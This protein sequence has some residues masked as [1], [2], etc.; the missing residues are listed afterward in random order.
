[1][2]YLERR[3]YKKEAGNKYHIDCNELSTN[4]NNIEITDAIRYKND[5]SILSGVIKNIK[6]NTIPNLK[7]T[8]HIVAKI[9]YSD[10]TLE[11][12]WQIGNMLT[13]IPGY[14][15]YICLFGCFDDSYK[16]ENP[17]R[18]CDAEK[19]PENNKK[20]LIMPYILEVSIK[21]FKWTVD[22]F[23]I[24]RS[25]IIQSIMSAL[26]AYQKIGFIHG[27]FHLD[28]ILLKKTKKIHIE[29]TLETDKGVKVI[30]IPS[31][32]Y[33]IVIMDFENSW[34]IKDKNNESDNLFWLNL[35]NMIS[36]LNWDLEDNDKNKVNF[37][38]L[39]NII[40]YID[41]Q[42]EQNSNCYKTNSIIKI[43]NEMPI[44]INKIPKQ[45]FE[46]NPNIF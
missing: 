12:E 40:T 7:N 43:I 5:V 4:T 16:K 11:K 1:M 38:N 8:R 39:S 42:K 29:Y 19:K 2:E 44:K 22:K 25:V 30:K 9:G 32:G 15:N 23:D 35:N 36:R 3:Y 18:I 31:N 33:K 6:N 13:G 20:V 21:S 24:L 17:T 37:I 27:D 26:V 10:K 45:Q 28:N 41:K 46:Y 34:I 14:I